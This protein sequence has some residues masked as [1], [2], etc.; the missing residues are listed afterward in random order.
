M[1]HS[2]RAYLIL[3]D[4]HLEV[5]QRDIMPKVLGH[6]QG[7]GVEQTKA[8][9]ELGHTVMTLYLGSVRVEQ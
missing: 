3:L 9:V 5:A 6:A 2:R 7:N 4:L 1:G 8:I